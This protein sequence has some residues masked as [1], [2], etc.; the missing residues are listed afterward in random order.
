MEEKTLP[1]LLVSMEIAKKK[2]QERIDKGQ[3]LLDQEIRSETELDKVGKE[4]N[5]WSRYNIAYL[6]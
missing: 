5:N 6:A 1:K 4:S 2:I 3:L